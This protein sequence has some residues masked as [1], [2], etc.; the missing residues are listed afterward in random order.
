ML[1][2]NLCNVHRKFGTVRRDKA[3]V[4][5]ALR[6]RAGAGAVLQVMPA[7]ISKLSDMRGRPHHR[8]RAVNVIAVEDVAAAFCL[9]SQWII[10]T[11]AISS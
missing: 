1:P 5:P 11:H 6:Q 2:G 7:N 3:C 4:V 9:F 8:Q 10:I